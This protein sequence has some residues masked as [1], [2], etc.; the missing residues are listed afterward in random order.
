MI[1]AIPSIQ[2]VFDFETVKIG[3]I[4]MA[5]AVSFLGVFWI[6]VWKAWRRRKAS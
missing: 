6:E 3:Q 4:G 5:L 2:A 1:L